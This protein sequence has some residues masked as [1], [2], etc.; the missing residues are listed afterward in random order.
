MARY[1][2][3]VHAKAICD[4]CGLSYPYLSLKPEWTGLR[5]CPE[6]W[7]YKHPSLDPRNAVDAESLQFARAGSHKREDARVTILRGVQTFV[8]TGQEGRPLVSAGVTLSET[9]FAVTTTLNTDGFNLMAGNDI[10][11]T[12]TGLQ[13]TTTV[14]A[15]SLNISGVATPSGIAVTTTVGAESLRSDTTLAVS[16]VTT[17]MA[18]GNETPQAAAIES[19]FGVTTTVGTEAV[20]VRGWG[21]NTWGQDTWGHD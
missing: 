7:D 10:H 12:E 1:A 2:K 17:T 4:R 13:V 5:T 19:G 8:R 6:C 21:N 15:E 14:G 18:L 20:S 9:G 11:A 3:G 16:N